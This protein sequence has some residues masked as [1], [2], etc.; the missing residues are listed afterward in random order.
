MVVMSKR[1]ET[2]TKFRHRL[3]PEVVFAW[4]ILNL[5]LFCLFS[6]FIEVKFAQ[7]LIE[8]YD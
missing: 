8:S 6:V 2:Y 1:T 5:L 7:E 3:L 4:F